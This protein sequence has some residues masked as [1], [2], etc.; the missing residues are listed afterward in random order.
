MK[1]SQ[2]RFSRATAFLLCVF[3]FLGQGTVPLLADS[4]VEPQAV[5]YSSGDTITPA[6]NS[7]T[8]KIRT[9]CYPV[10][11]ECTKNSD[12]CSGICRD[13]HGHASYCYPKGW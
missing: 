12:C 10:H 8:E 13:W 9:A 5:S 1:T 4:T 11:G 7:I 2:F 3:A 6:K